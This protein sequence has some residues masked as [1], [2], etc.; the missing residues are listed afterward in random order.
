MA[1]EDL[2]V[3][4]HRADFAD[5]F[6]Q[7]FEGASEL[8]APLLTRFPIAQVDSWKSRCSGDLVFTHHEGVRCGNSYAAN[9]VPEVRRTKTYRGERRIDSPY[10]PASTGAS[11]KLPAGADGVLSLLGQME[12]L[13]MLRYIVLGLLVAAPMGWAA[14]AATADID[15]ATAFCRFV[16][17]KKL[18]NPPGLVWSAPLP[19]LKDARGNLEVRVRYRAEGIA[20]KSS[21]CK[22]RALSNGEMQE[23][24]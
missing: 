15:D 16:T 1:Q 22:V 21:V 19:V 2:H 4:G 8:L 13:D 20:T 23:I 11:G 7:L 3:L 9:L 10:I 14:D 12:L 24:R 6:R 5:G 17:R 18:G